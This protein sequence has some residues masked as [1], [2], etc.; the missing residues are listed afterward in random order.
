MLLCR[1]QLLHQEHGYGYT[2]AIIPGREE[3]LYAAKIQGRSLSAIAAELG[4]SLKRLAS[5]GALGAI[6]AAPPSTKHRG[7]GPPQAFS[8]AS[9]PSSPSRPWPSN[10]Y[11]PLGDPIVC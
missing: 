9:R 6:T 7:D 2:S 8:P 4:C 5:G 10:E 3:R 1:N 11:I